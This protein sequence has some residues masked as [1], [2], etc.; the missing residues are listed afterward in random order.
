LQSDVAVSHFSFELSARDES[1]D[2]ID[3]DQIDCIG[4]DESRC[5]LESLF[6]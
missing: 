6:A 3:D 4:G 2:G 5:D 1:G